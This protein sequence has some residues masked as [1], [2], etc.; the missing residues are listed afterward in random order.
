MIWPSDQLYSGGTNSSEWLLP[1]H[2]TLNRSVDT[3]IPLESLVG[4]QQLPLRLLL[5]LSDVPQ[6]ADNLGTKVRNPFIAA[7]PNPRPPPPL[8]QVPFRNLVLSP[9][10]WTT[11]NS[12][13]N[14]IIQ[15]KKASTGPTI[16]VTKNC[17]SHPRSKARTPIFSLL[18]HVNVHIP[19]F[20]SHLTYTR[21]LFLS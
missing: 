8:L 3:P 17:M 14:C 10:P 21:F 18:L 13:P 12:E 9:L 2:S 20:L 19:Y 4:S 15:S 11:Y 7:S 1:R 16:R 6:R 5:Q